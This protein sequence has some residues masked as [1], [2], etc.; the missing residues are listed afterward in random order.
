MKRTP[1]LSYQAGAF[2]LF[3]ALL[4]AGCGLFEERNPDDPNRRY[5]KAIFPERTPLIAAT[6]EATPDTQAFYA[7]AEV[8]VGLIEEPLDKDYVVYLDP[9]VEVDE[10]IYSPT[11]HAQVMEFAYQGH[12]RPIPDT[13]A[14][15]VVTGPTGT[16]WEQRVV[17]PHH[18]AGVYVDTA[19]RLVMLAGGHYQLDVHMQDGRHYQSEMRLA[20]Q[21]DWSIPD[22]LEVEV[23]RLYR[24]RSGNCYEESDLWENAPRLPDPQT[25]KDGSLAAM[26]VNYSNDWEVFFTPPGGFRFEDRGNYRREGGTYS[27][28][29]PAAHSTGMFGIG[30]LEKASPKQGFVSEKKAWFRFSQMEWNLSRFYFNEFIEFLNLNGDPSNDRYWNT[31]PD[32]IFQRN[33]DYFFGV[34]NIKKVGENGELL[35]K[36]DAVGVFGGYSSVYRSSVIIPRRT[37]N[38]TLLETCP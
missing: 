27:I 13:G 14:E 31:V 1:R 6:F 5:D 33:S 34:S 15:V 30:W 9:A 37:W 35:P 20:S 11:L 18:R 8:F 17:L 21:P 32:A 36:S 2:P 4:T 19:E 16:A 24:E 38:L 3:L 25:V 26:Q 10:A 22:T 23:K 29:T 12:F 28:F 7:P